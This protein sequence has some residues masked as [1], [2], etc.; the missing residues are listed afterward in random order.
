M[1]KAGGL[2]SHMRRAGGGA[3]ESH[4]KGWGGG[5]A[6]GSHVKGWRA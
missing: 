1:R 3:I 5:G 2:L 4:E 6:V